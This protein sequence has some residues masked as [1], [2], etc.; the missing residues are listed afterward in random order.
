MLFGAV[1]GPCGGLFNTFDAAFTAAG[2]P[3]DYSVVGIAFTVVG[4]YLACMLPAVNRTAKADFS[5][6]FFGACGVLSSGLTVLGILQ[7]A[8]NLF[9]GWALLLD[10]VVGFYAVIATV[11]N[12]LGMK[13]PFGKPFVQ[14]R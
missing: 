11:S 8:F 10:G 12:S 6:F 5:I 13:P 4:L 1:F 14:P 3:L 9:N 7:A 2:I